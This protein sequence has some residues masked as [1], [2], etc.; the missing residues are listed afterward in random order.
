MSDFPKTRHELLRARYERMDTGGKRCSGC[1]APIEW[2]KT[3]NGRRIPMDPM[4]SDSAE[5]KAHWA[6]CP[7][8]KDFRGNQVT[9]A[10]PKPSAFGPTREDQ[11]HALREKHGA[12]VVVM[13][14]ELGTVASWDARIPAEDLRSDLIS[15]ANFVRKEIT[16]K[17]GPPA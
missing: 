16:G 17:D 2:W 5:A 7:N 9:P 8:G 4:A 10:K 1:D 11:A 6:T 14:D 15:A 12:R 3:T 13:I